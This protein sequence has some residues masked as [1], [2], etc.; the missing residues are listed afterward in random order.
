MVRSM[1]QTAQDAA[2]VLR[3]SLVRNGPAPATFRAALTGICAED[4]DAWLDLLWDID[5]LP[6]DDP[7]LPR[8]CVPY[9]PCPVATVLEAVQQAAVTSDDVFVDVGA[10]LGR[11][12]VLTHLLTGAGCIGLEIQPGLVQA[13]RGRAAWLNLSHVRF[14]E[15]DAVDLIRF[16]TI[17]TVFF[18]YCPFGQDRLHRVLD[19]LEH[20]A[21]TRPIRVC[22]VGLPPLDRPWLAPVPSTSVDLVVYRSTLHQA[23][24][25]PTPIKPP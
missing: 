7:L 9:L 12:A 22:C 6:E 3:S 8:G 16:I 23:R 1:R 17:G 14:V 5:E 4:R 10:G 24:P 11:V 15:G 2:K 20:T 13:A 18:L 21:R 25:S 19:D